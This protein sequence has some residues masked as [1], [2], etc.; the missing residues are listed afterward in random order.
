MVC[1]NLEQVDGVWGG[2]QG[3]MQT[4]AMGEERVWAKLAGPPGSLTA[5]AALKV[6]G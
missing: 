3:K 6:Y 2:D 5:K 1:R 4:G